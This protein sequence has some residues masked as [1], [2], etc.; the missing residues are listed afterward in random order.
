MNMRFATALLIPIIGMSAS[1]FAEA[2]YRV[3]HIEEAD[4]PTSERVLYALNCM[5]DTGEG[6]TL[7]SLYTC[8]CRI[9]SIAKQ[10]VFVDYE[11]GTTYERNR[12]MTGEKGSVVRDNKLAKESYA[13]LEKARKVA[14]QECPTVVRVKNPNIE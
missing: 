13:K 11:L 3:A 6:Q 5:Q 9:D 1:T 12:R 7:E 2:D 10:M 4:Y 14:E 8:S